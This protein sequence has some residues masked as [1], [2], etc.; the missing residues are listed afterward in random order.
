MKNFNFAEVVSFFYY[1]DPKTCQLYLFFYFFF[2]VFFH[3]FQPKLL[4]ISPSLF[5]LLK[6]TPLILCYNQ[7]YLHQINH[8]HRL[9]CKF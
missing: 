7:Y 1:L 5:L 8:I 9:Y 4:V 6:N 3:R 2:H